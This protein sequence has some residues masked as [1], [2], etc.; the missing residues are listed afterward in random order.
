MRP[1]SAPHQCLALGDGRAEMAPC[2]A[3]GRRGGGSRASPGT[4]R[5]RA[6]ALRASPAS[7][8]TPASST[9]WLTSA[10]PASASRASAARAA[11][12]SSRGWLAWTATQVALPGAFS[13]AT[14]SGVTVSG[15][16]TGTRV[17]KRSTFTCGI[18]ARAATR[19]ARR[20]G[21][22][23]EG[24]A[25]ADDHLPDLGLGADIGERVVEGLGRQRTGA[26]RTDRL[27]AEAEAAI[28]RA[29]M[30]ELQ[31][32][33]V[34]VAV[35]QAGHDLMG[36]VADRI[37]ALVRPSSRARPRP[38]GTGGRSGRPG[39]PGRSVRPSRA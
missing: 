8:L 15:A 32:H 6:S 4:R 5:R 12:V 31:E 38:A 39:R 14:S 30:D 24:I 27:A 18:A 34:G 1:R 11:G 23:D 21:P 29:D 9:V 17:W 3:R 33:P 13:A 28:D 7:S 36:A 35:D 10:M 26:G 25:A 20:R 22:S 2:R 37:G 19:A 16:T